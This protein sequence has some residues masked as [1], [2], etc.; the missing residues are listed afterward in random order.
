MRPIVKDK[1]VRT[2]L[3]PGKIPVS[4]SGEGQGWHDGSTSF[5]NK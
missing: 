3:G 4:S 1:I 5:S 2:M